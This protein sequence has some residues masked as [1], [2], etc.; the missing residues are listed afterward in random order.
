MRTYHPGNGQK[1]SIGFR[2]EP[3]GRYRMGCTKFIWV[4]VFD[5]MNS[6]YRSIMTFRIPL[7]VTRRK[8][9]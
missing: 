9:A 8:D 6:Y 3:G 4:F 7:F 1:I 2:R 5:W